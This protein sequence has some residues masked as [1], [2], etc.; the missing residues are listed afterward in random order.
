MVFR[1]PTNNEEDTIWPRPERARPVNLAPLKGLLE[2]DQVRSKILRLLIED[3][4]WVTTTDLLRVA[5]Q[6]RPV[7]GAVTVGTIL[8]GMNELISS[9]FILSRT[10]LNSGLD[11]AE[12]RINPDLLEPT[13]KLLQMLNRVRAQSEQRYGEYITST[14][15]DEFSAK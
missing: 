13:R 8:K 9:S 5:R 6:V 14:R 4:G 3:G 11:W 1:Q 10:S 7:I 2:S 15:R 12:W